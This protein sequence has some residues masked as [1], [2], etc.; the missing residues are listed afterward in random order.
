MPIRAFGYQTRAHLDYSGK[1]SYL[2]KYAHESATAL[3]GV[4]ESIRMARHARG[5]PNEEERDLLRGM[6]VFSASGVDGM[7]KQLIRDSLPELIRRG[8]EQVRKKLERFVSAE[9]AKGVEKTSDVGA[10]FLG[11]LLAAEHHQERVVEEYVYELTGSSL[12]SGQELVDAVVA[13]GQNPA[14]LGIVANELQEIFN[15]RNKIIHELDIDW[16]SPNRNRCSRRIG[17]TVNQ[18]NRLLEVGETILA[19]VDEELAP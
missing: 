13:L 16:E 18:T 9:I 5:A 1:A 15:E 4:F 2:L 12:Q 10:K 14:D 6:L 19:A 7:T 8:H 17:V 3:L 11:R